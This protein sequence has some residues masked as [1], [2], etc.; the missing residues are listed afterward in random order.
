MDRL[1]RLKATFARITRSIRFRLALWFVAILALILA[2]FSAFIYTRQVREYT[3]ETTTRL[4]GKSR[5]LEAYYRFTI[6]QAFER[7]HGDILPPGTISTE[8]PLLTDE[9]TLLLA[10]S[11]GAV[12]QQLGPL[13][14]GDITP[15]Q[16]AAQR[17]IASAGIQP[18]M[19]VVAFTYALNKPAATLTPDY[20]FVASLI[21]LRDTFSIV[22]ILGSP[23][24]SARLYQLALTLVVG[25]LGL[26]LVALGGGYWLAG[27][28]MRPV[29]I[30]TQTARQ[31]SDTDLSKRLK[32]GGHDELSEL[33][34]TFD[35]MLDRLQAS[36]ERQRQFTADASHELRTPLTIIELEASRA[37]GHPRSVEEY[38]SALMTIKS[39]NEL[40]SR[41]VNDLLTLAR[42]D[43]GQTILRSESLDLSDVALDVVERLSPLAK[44]KHVELIAGDLPVVG[45]RGDRQFLS[46]M[47]TNL[48]ENAIKYSAPTPQGRTQ[49]H[50]C[51]HVETGNGGA[52]AWVRIQDNGPGI[53][54]DLVPKLFD[55]FYRVDEARGHNEDSGLDEPGKP[56]PSGS[57]LGLSIVQWIVKSHGGK[58]NVA[59]QPGQGS[60]FEVRLPAVRQN[61]P[62][63]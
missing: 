55:R 35:Q 25:S 57:G 38:E 50:A 61:P 11:R 7:D 45:V 6:R 8:M 32:L 44:Q 9:E 18:V 20:Q 41:M 19:G 56:R 26:L 2:G 1:R 39:E 34:G 43:A 30:I 22:I 21:P 52:D 54:A 46:Q 36:F 10:D 48:V 12:I 47:L 63:Q 33:A 3:R 42:M 29:Q 60:T 37:L 51:V 49:L 53:P 31:I 62:N 40:M 23:L 15:L 14:Q 5:Q 28:V 27:R 59:S 58:V 24:D 4:E 17:A 16:E 13:T